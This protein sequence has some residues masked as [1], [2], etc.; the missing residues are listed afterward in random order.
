MTHNILKGMDLTESGAR[1]SDELEFSATAHGG[2]VKREVLDAHLESRDILNRAREEA[3][4]IKEQTE[5]TLARAEQER[6][7]QRQL[8]FAEGH[9]E[10]LDELTE[11]VFELEGVREEMLAKSEG[12][13]VQMVMEIAEKVIGKE[14]KR[15]AIVSIVKKSIQESVGQKVVIHVHPADLAVLKKKEKELLKVLEGRQGMTLRADE[16]LIPGGCMIETEVGTI[17]A[18]LEVQIGAIRKALRLPTTMSPEL[19][20]PI[21][22]TQDECDEGPRVIPPDEIESGV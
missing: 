5:Q 20:H 4:K 11:K 9:Q 13:M 7:E 12:D 22:P 17:D 10:G 14:L 6:E 8:G 19:A 1:R 21:G 18:R 3:R 15:G 16:T 2:L